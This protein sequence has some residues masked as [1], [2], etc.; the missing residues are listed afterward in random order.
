[1]KVIVCGAG[2]VGSSIARPLAAE[3]NDVTVIDRSGELVRMLTDSL[4]VQGVVGFASHPDVLERAG[5][6]DA[7]MLI[8]V[9]RDDEVNMV[10]CQVAHSL[11]N[12]PT[13]IA[14]VRQ[15]SYLQPIWADLFT[16]ENMP[17]D[18]II[19]PEIEIAR[20]IGRRL[21]APGAFDMIPLADGKVRVI[22]V[23]CTE[24]CPVINTP[25]RQLTGLFPDL[26][27]VVV[28]IIRDG[29]PLV[30]DE[31]TQ[32]RAGDD[33]Y[34]VADSEH[35]SRV[36]A[37]FGHEEPE[38]RR[39]II[40]GAG[41]IGLYLAHMIGE[42]HPAA[43]LKMIEVNKEAAERASQ[44]LSRTVV[45][46]GNAI[47][48]EIMA[49]ANVA[50]AETAVFVTNS[51]EANVL[52]S[53]LAKRHGCQRTV[54]LVNNPVFGPLLYSLGIDVVVSPRVITVS[55]ILQHVRRGRIR[56]VHTLGE[57]FGEIVEAD[58][59]ETSPLVGTPLREIALPK[60][61]V[62]GA[63]VRDDEVIIPRGD[64]VI[65][66]GDRVVLFAAAEAVTKV[67]KMLAVRPE[68]F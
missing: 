16:R 12:V 49:E 43:T 25:L 57:G 67:A 59:L 35:V 2:Q 32:M 3:E 15:Q 28:L 31:K 45:I 44:V 51:D 36:M 21:Q 63:L 52:A 18:V 65:K 24:E 46:Q 38:A 34:F 14:R 5:A 1:M 29:Q 10:A 13:K 61:V 58:A 53:L 64:T 27:I 22:G 4:D 30:R 62:V 33:V 56:S 40:V 48:P 26:N 50:K 7:D 11:F 54:T 39:I 47:D 20:A 37:A 55:S 8:A 60:G 17:I 41:N 9:T 68:Y 6:A 42:Q 19:S 23:H 66:A